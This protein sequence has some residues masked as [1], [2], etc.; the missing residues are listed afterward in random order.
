MTEFKPGELFVYVNGERWEL[1]QVKSKA[2]DDAYFCWYSTGDT[3]ACTPV[4]C[5]HK[6]ANAGWS[7]VERSGDDYWCEMVPSG[8]GDDVA[9]SKCGAY[10]I[11]SKYYDGYSHS[12]TLKRCPECG[13]H[14][15]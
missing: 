12:T 9:C 4:S 14:V 3:A 6:L 1:G 15:C 7:H 13:R 11:Y 5:M 8:A 2:R 10:N